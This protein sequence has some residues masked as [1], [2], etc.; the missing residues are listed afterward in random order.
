MSVTPLEYHGGRGRMK[1][2]KRRRRMKKKKQRINLNTDFTVSLR[3]V[4][5]KWTNRFL[6][7]PSH[8]IFIFRCSSTTGLQGAG[9]YLF[10]RI[11]AGLHVIPIKSQRYTRWIH[12]ARCRPL[13][14]FIDLFLDDREF[15]A[16]LTFTFCFS[17]IWQFHLWEAGKFSP[18]VARFDVFCSW[19]TY[20]IYSERTWNVVILTFWRMN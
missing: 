3:R 18:V 16:E 20:W 6:L 12:V 19:R 5:S 8:G 2:R 1:R 10:Y 13:P 7:F 14:S 9:G 11:K 17:F 4:V 15:L